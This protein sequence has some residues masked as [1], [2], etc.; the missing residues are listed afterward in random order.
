VSHFHI[1]QNLTEL[2]RKAIGGAVGARPR[3]E[4]AAEELRAFDV[5]I[6]RAQKQM[7][8]EMTLRLKSL[9]VPFFG[10]KKEFIVSTSDDL[11]FDGS[12]DRRIDE[13]QLLGLQRRMIEILEDLCA[14]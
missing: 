7:V 14:E 12:H 9:G 5:K 8:A 11:S 10:T 6:H 3:P 13:K 4:D 2:S 1:L